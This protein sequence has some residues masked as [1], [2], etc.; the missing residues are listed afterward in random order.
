MVVLSILN[1]GLHMRMSNETQCCGW[2]EW[3]KNCYEKLGSIYS[4]IFSL[5]SSSGASLRE[6]VVEKQA[7]NF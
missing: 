7:S 2:P 5:L 3:E 6:F 1:D 4:R